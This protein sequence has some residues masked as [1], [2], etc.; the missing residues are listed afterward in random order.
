M[1]ALLNALLLLTLVTAWPAM[2]ETQQRIALVVGNSAYTKVPALKNPKN[3]ANLMAETLREA[4]FD[5]VLALDADR[6]ALGRAI[7]DFGT[8]LRGAGRTAV[9]LFY[10][11][12]HGVQYD[13]QNYLIPL[14]A[15]IDF[16]SDLD[17]EAVEL[18]DVLR[19]MALSGSSFNMAILDACRNNPYPAAT[20]ATARGLARVN[21]HN[22]SLVAF[23][24]APG[25]VA[26]DGTGANSPY[27]QALAAAIRTP[28]LTVPEVVPPHPRRRAGGHQRRPDA[29]GRELAHRPVLLHRV[30]G[31]RG[32]ATNRSRP[33]RAAPKP[34]PRRWRSPSGTR[35]RTAATPTSLKPIS[36][37]IR[38]VSSR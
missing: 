38:T 23:A 17:L 1:R 30:A 2:A 33:R 34:A 25:E 9:G 32:G 28:G 26:N 22:S 21:S 8:R 31:R 24:A 35:S 6:R 27:T 29:V 12:G 3:D 10:F 11:A 13:G 19:Q 4:G 7:R 15:Q 36:S 20:R 14:N 37:A 16:A 18:D 5:V